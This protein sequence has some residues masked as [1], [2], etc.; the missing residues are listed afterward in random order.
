MTTDPGDLVLDPTC[1]SG[2]TAYVAEQWGRRWITIDTSRVALALARMRV[3]GA[4]YP[5][6]LLADS[7]EGQSKEAQVARRPIATTPVFGRLRQGFVYERVPHVTLKAIANNAEIDEIPARWEPVAAGALQRLNGALSDHASPFAVGTGGRAGQAVRFNAPA[8]AT[9]ALPSGDTASVCALLEWEVPRE[10]PADWP[11]SSHAPLEAFW[12]A[13]VARQ[14]KMDAS[15]A[16]RAEFEY[17]YDRPYEDRARV[18]V[19]GPFTVESV[20]PHRVVGIGPDGEAIDPAARARSGVGGQSFVDLILQQLAKAGIQQADRGARITLAA[21]TAYPGLHIH[22]TATYVEN[23]RTV[24]AAIAIGP[25]FGTVTRADLV[26]AALEAADAN[27]DVL[28]SCAFAFEAHTTEFDR[29]GRVTVLKVRMNGDL[30]MAGDLKASAGNLFV[31]FGDPDIDVLDD[32][33]GMVKVRVN[34]IDI[35]DPRRGEIRSSGPDDIACWFIDTNYSDES[36]CVRH[37]YFLGANDPYGALKRTLKAE[38]DEDAWQS[39]RRDVS[40]PFPRPETGR[41]AVKVI[42]HLGDEA[43]KVLRVEAK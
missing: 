7:K 3:M 22:A 31:I 23:D 12:D 27:F 30:H 20:S 35:Y 8:D 16:A 40:R 4:R 9:V 41:I 39:L 19:A 14:R 38:V 37:A 11:A 1:G 18:R 25:E 34:G 17:L 21:I 5:Y 36:F 28:V 15:I 24:R 13:R 33:D 42:N 10:A 6:Y 32:A 29:L 2:T 26:E 43:L